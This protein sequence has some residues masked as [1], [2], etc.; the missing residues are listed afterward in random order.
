MSSTAPAS[1]HEHDSSPAVDPA[2]GIDP[3]LLTA[4]ALWAV[5]RRPLG[6]VHRVGDDAVAELDAVIASEIKIDYVSI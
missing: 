6:P 5:F 4:Y 3:N 1:A 2:T